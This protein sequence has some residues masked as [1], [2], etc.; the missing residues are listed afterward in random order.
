MDGLCGNKMIIQIQEF[1]LHFY[2][3]LWSLLT[4]IVTANA[5]I[6]WLLILSDDGP[7]FWL[8]IEWFGCD[9]KLRIVVGAGM[10]DHVKNR[11]HGIF[12]GVAKW[13][14]IDEMIAPHVETPEISHAALGRV[15]KQLK[16]RH[17]AGFG[18]KWKELFRESIEVILHSHIANQQI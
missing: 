9:Y 17:M 1:C 6:G 4:V 15:H 12:L 13:P 10:I 8:W 11:D 2:S 5:L 14:A 18:K 3:V 16:H 7:D